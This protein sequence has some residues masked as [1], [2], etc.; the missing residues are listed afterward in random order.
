MQL[1]IVIFS[2][3]A[4]S[5]LETPPRH[6]RRFI[7]RGIIASDEGVKRVFEIEDPAANF[8]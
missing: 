7:L 2:M 1:F 3:L 5:K 6:G 4:G 8:Q